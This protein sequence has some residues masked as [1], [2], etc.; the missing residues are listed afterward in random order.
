MRNAFLRRRSQNTFRPRLE[1]LETRL[2]PTT[3]TVSSLA[4]SGAGSL[5]A[6]ITSVNGDS[7]QND[8]IDFSVAGVIKLTSG[9]LPPITNANNSVKIDGTTAPGFVNAPVVEI[10]NNGFAGLAID[11][12]FVALASLSIVNA[13][14]PGLTLDGTEEG[15]VAGFISVTGNY[16]G[17]ALDGSMAAN[18]G[19]GLLDITPGRNT[20][21]GTNSTDRNVIS[22]NGGGGIQLGLSTEPFGQ[23]STI[24]GNYIGT[25][26]TGKAAAANQ[27]N[28]IFL[29]A[30]EGGAVIGG[31]D[32]AAGNIIAFNTES[33]VLGPRGIQNQIL[34]NS[35]FS[36]GAKGI[37]LQNG[38]DLELP[39]PPQL[40]YAVESPGSTT[41]SVQV[42][43]GGFL[44]APYLT[45]G[46]IT[47]QVFATM[48]GVPAG[49]GQI[50]LGNAEAKVSLNGYAAF[51]FS[52]ASAP[53][54][55]G[56]TFTATASAINTSEFSNAIG[57]S[58][59][60]QA[61]NQNFVTIA[62]GFL[63]HRVPDPSS[64]HWVNLLNNGTTP[65]QVLLNIQGSPEYLSD[66]VSAMY[67]SYLKR[68]ADQ[69]GLQFWTNFLL[70]GG[71]F[72]QVAAELVSSP[73]YFVLH[74]STNQG[75][76]TGL[77]QD[78]L[79]RIVS[80][81]ES[82]NWVAV[83]NSGVPRLTVATAFLTSQEYRTDLVQFDYTTFLLRSADSGGL[84]TWVNALN[85]GAT[86]QQV[87]AGIFGSPEGYRLWS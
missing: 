72:E 42:Q 27:G 75:F 34:S 12:T 80:N 4:D 66:Q 57:S 61:P 37:E 79:N 49:Q 82:A 41:D 69:Q 43:V 64:A 71:T 35:I 84:T 51:T 3:Y 19:V 10:D 58:T 26:P 85:V 1:A 2:T 29:A 48:S 62:Y 53:A 28:G 32:P 5:R 44:D 36:N 68:A 16:I 30:S 52:G 33:G 50:F 54:G 11:A 77:Y 6:A 7:H 22:G 25:D 45:N 74:G 17:L 87:L 65:A 20:I 18:S 59:P 31:T 40:Y 23:N 14:G 46:T 86:D 21:G 56:T 24:E 39:P 60:D 8:V 67:T 47:I 76:V 81:A 73:E 63:L 83:L 15:G 9:P 70:A 38:M 78:V 55:S 13:N